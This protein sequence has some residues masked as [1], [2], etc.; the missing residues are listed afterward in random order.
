VKDSE[1]ETFLV[2][3]QEVLKP[4]FRIAEHFGV[5]GHELRDSF[6]Q[7][8]VEFFA[9]QINSKEQR[10][11]SPARVAMYAGLNQAE[12]IDRIRRRGSAALTLARRSQLLSELLNAWHTEPGYAGVYD[13]ARELPFEAEDSKPSFSSLCEKVSPGADPRDLLDDLEASRCIEHLD[14]GFIRPLTRAYVLPAGNVARLDRMG[15]VLV[16]FT[17]SYAKGIVGDA[18]RFTAFSE[19]TLVSDFALSDRGAK[20]FNDEVRDRGT[21]LLT[22]LDSWLTTQASAVSDQTGR[23]FGCGL[24]VFEDAASVGRSPISLEDSP[25]ADTHLHSD[26]D[27]NGPVVVDVLENVTQNQKN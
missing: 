15:K 23:R 9:E 1:R 17:E 27:S 19:R 13:I 7:S 20:L 21:K 11:A 6:A 25:G 22:D 3:F 10:A 16:N 18:G 2:A 12:V 26:S 8:A 4:F 24:Y 5:P 14:G